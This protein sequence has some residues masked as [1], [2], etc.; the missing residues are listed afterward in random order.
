MV[1]QNSKGTSLC[2]LPEAQGLLLLEYKLQL[3]LFSHVKG[4]PDGMVRYC[5][6]RMKIRQKSCDSTGEKMYCRTT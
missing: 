1:R 4:V 3:D 6:H 5:V 2:E